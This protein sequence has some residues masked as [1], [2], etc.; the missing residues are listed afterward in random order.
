MMDDNKMR[1]R[2]Y[3]A[4]FVAATLLAIWLSGSACCAAGIRHFGTGDGCE[5][6]DPMTGAVPDDP[7]ETGDTIVLCGSLSS[8]DLSGESATSLI[9]TGSGY[10][11]GTIVGCG[12]DADMRELDPGGPIVLGGSWGTVDV[13]WNFVAP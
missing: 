13:N 11:G 8:I 3:I 7:I 6:S 1:A 9:F 5:E 4:C 10:S 12:A 2:G